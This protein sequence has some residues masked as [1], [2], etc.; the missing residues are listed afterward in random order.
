MHTL[1]VKK[2]QFVKTKIE[3][4]SKGQ[5]CSNSAQVSLTQLDSA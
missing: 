5:N 4:L 3:N 1:S 2:K